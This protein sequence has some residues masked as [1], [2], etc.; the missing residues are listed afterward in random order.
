MESSQ[1]GIAKFKAMWEENQVE[2]GKHFRVG[3]VFTLKQDNIPIDTT[4]V[5]REGFGQ[6]LS[7][8]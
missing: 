3:Y 7:K 8:S 4:R 1:S 6:F 2:A 5:L